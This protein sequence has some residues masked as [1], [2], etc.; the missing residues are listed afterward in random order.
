[1]LFD[2]TGRPLFAELSPVTDFREAC[3]RQ[4]ES[5][6]CQRGGF[7][8]FMH[9][10]HP[11]PRLIRTLNHEQAVEAR[12]RKR[13]ERAAKRERSGGVKEESGAV[14][15]D[16]PDWKKGSSGGDWRGGGRRS[17]SPQRV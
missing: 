1:M 12:E 2:T 6:E 11:N 4:H 13:R 3:C 16:I 15:R 10:R 9:V 5:N 8:N 14:D 7:C 17:Q